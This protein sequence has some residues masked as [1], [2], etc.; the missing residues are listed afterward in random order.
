MAE[1]TNIKTAQEVKESFTGENKEERKE[2]T[3][4]AEINEELVRMNQKLADLERMAQ[5]SE[6]MLAGLRGTVSWQQSVMNANTKEIDV[7]LSA[8]QNAQQQGLITL[9]VGADGGM[10]I[11][12]RITGNVYLSGLKFTGK[13]SDATKPW[14]KVDVANSTVTEQTGP[15]SNPFPPG[16][17]WYEKNKHVGDIHVTRL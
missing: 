7:M 3:V 5:E 6:G 16:E 14:I 9:Q 8:L 4:S 11:G 15:P 13:N 2:D 1:E 12:T 17:E 10:T